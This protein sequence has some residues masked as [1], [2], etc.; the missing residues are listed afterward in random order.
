MKVQRFLSPRVLADALISSVVAQGELF[1]FEE[2]FGFVKKNAV[3]G[4][5]LIKFCYFILSSL[6][7]GKS[8]KSENQKEN[9]QENLSSLDGLR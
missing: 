4:K 7:E 2:A 3:R 8:G 5:Y 9:V 6:R 1:D